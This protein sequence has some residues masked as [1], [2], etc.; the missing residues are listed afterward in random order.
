[1]S[2]ER[3]EEFPHDVD[4]LDSKHGRR[5]TKL[6]FDYVDDTKHL[7]VPN[8]RD[9]RVLKL[10]LT[11]ILNAASVLDDDEV[12]A[13][14][15]QFSELTL[16]ITDQRIVKHIGTCIWDDDFEEFPFEDVTGLSFEPGNVA[17]QVVVEIDGRPQ[18]IKAPNDSARELRQT[19][20][21]KLFDYYG[22]ASL[23]ELN[24]SLGEDDDEPTVDTE[25]A[26]PNATESTT[27]GRDTADSDVTFSD[28]ID[29]LVPDSSADATDDGEPI[30]AS[31]SDE[32]AGTTEAN[33]TAAGLSTDADLS[34]SDDLEAVHD[35]IDELSAA[36]QRHNELLERQEAAIKQLVT[37]LRQGR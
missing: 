22:V 23:S 35:R 9:Q 13:G 25:P 34:D 5:K 30:A 7:T 36:V 37:E 21:E 28:G 4:R 15:Y 18:R 32:A 31:I 10:V 3:L 14:V 27:Q 16:V 11:G 12:V 1:L 17:T 33:A 24:A 6:V 29:P 2:D 8:A 20:E 19:V 26:D